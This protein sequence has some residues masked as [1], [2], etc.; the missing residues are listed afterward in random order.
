MACW[1]GVLGTLTAGRTG[2]LH[3]AR[4]GIVLRWLRPLLVQPGLAS[5]VPGVFSHTTLVDFVV[6]YLVSNCTKGNSL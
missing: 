1:I 6:I 2:L 3:A 5:G 4:W